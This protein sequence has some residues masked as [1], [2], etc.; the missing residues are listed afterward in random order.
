MRRRSNGLR[1]QWP[2]RNRLSTVSCRSRTG[3]VTPSATR[4][5][6][7]RPHGKSKL[8]IIL[9]VA[10]RATNDRPNGGERLVHP[11]KRLRIVKVESGVL[12]GDWLSPRLLQAGVFKLSA[13]GCP[14]LLLPNDPCAFQMTIASQYELAGAPALEAIC[15]TIE[16]GG[17]RVQE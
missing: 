15:R 1:N 5:R 4:F 10:N 16:T 6:S 12:T 17:P 7:F 9:M 8:A 14:L 11:F 13:T 2:G 3:S